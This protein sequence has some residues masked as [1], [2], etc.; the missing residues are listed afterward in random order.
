MRADR[1]H[2][3]A[4]ALAKQHRQTNNNRCY[5][6]LIHDAGCD[7]NIFVDNLGRGV[8]IACEA[9]PTFPMSHL[10]RTEQ[11]VGAIKEVSQ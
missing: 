8:Y 9:I 2:H 1:S 7:Y 4:A 6:P 11:E 3:R 10:A 5:K